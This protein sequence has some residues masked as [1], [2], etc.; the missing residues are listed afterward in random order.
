MKEQWIREGFS[1]YYVVKKE[2]KLTYEKNILHYHTLRGLLP[3]EFRMQDGE[4]YYYYETGI[5]TTLKDRINM[6]DPQLFFAYLIEIFEETESYLMD[7]D[8]LKLEAELLF[9]DKEDRPVLCYLPEYKKNIFEQ[10]R[11]FLEEC[12]EMV[13]GNDKKKVRFYYEFHSFLVKEKPNMRQM[14]EYLEIHMKECREKSDIKEIE[15]PKVFEEAKIEESYGSTT[16]IKSVV[17]FICKSLFVIICAGSFCGMIYF[18]MQILN[19]GF[20]YLFVI[21]L[22]ASAVGI[23]VGV[24][25]FYKLWKNEKNKNQN[26][27]LFQDKEGHTILLDEKTTLLEDED[28]TVLLMEEPMGK[29]I[30]QLQGSEEILINDSEFIIGSSMEGTD[31]QINGTGISRRHLRFF[32]E[33]GEIYCEDLD[34]TNGVKVNGRKIKKAVLHDGDCIKIGLEEFIFKENE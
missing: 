23:V 4:E 28:K 19:Y 31:Y 13:S 25:G 7:L 21:G 2:Q 15:T 12:I 11:N 33:S 3:C 6:I 26:V 18:F 34:S 10:L 22:F 32:R 30:S 9:L 27:D 1:N 29:L 5:Y 20:Y 17:K 16:K 24:Y 8:H 14:K